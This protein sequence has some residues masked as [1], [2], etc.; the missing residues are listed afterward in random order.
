MHRETLGSVWLDRRESSVSLHM[1]LPDFLICISLSKFCPR[2]TMPPYFDE[3]DAHGF[4]FGTYQPITPYSGTRYPG[5]TGIELRDYTRPVPQYIYM[6][7]LS[8][9]IS[10]RR[11]TGFLVDQWP[12]KKARDALMR[13]REVINTPGWGPDILV[14]I[15]PDMDEAFSNGL[16]RCSIQVTWE[17]EASVRSSN[18][19]IP[20][21]ADN[22]GD[23]SFDDI[24]ETCHIRLNRRYIC[25]GHGGP[26]KLMLQVL[27]HEMVV[28]IRSTL[29]A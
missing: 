11:L 16:L 5:F 19:S 1:T 22:L 28:S 23:T 25:G 15:L 29:P 8:N 4:F 24:D 26:R 10:T 18:D 2:T 13:M 20:D 9:P 12:N 14:K 6:P 21:F 27:I 7:H 3:A 17:D